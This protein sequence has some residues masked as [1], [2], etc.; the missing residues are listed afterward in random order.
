MKEETFIFH[1]KENMK[2]FVYKW[3]PTQ[4]V[5][6]IVQI[7]HGVADHALR[8][9]YFAEKLT[10]QGFLVYA[11]DHRGHGNSVQ[12]QKNLGFCGE[13]GFNRMVENLHDL[14]QI[15]IK[16]HNDLPLFLF[17]HSMGSF[18]VQ[19]Y[20]CTYPTN[21]LTGV[22]LSGSNGKQSPL[23]LSVAKFVAKKRLAKFGST[24]RDELL[25]YLMF[26]N[27]NKKFKPSKT[28]FDWVSRDEQEVENYVNDPRCGF[29]LPSQYFYDLFRALKEM[30]TKQNLLKARKNLS[31]YIFSGDR[32]PV[33]NFGKGVTNLVSLYY[34]YGLLDVTYKLYPDGRHEMLN[35]INKDEVI[36]DT[37][38]WLEKKVVNE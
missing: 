16:T 24:Y 19:K 20:I 1:D 15:I 34:Q 36:Q 22:I 31:V 29:T 27:F 28:L 6:G 14:N 3:V 13:D 8:Y 30:Y 37:L 10:K 5:K 26:K 12:E 2:I 21:H 38:I 33:G 35:E 25:T 11:N 18:L 9:R 17:G 7:A 4:P 32:D 23:L